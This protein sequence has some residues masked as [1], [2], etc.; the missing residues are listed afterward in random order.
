MNIQFIRQCAKCGSRVYTLDE[1]AISCRV[2][3]DCICVT[4]YQERKTQPKDWWKKL[5]GIK[6]F[7]DFHKSPHLL[8]NDTLIETLKNEYLNGNKHV[9]DLQKLINFQNE[10]TLKGSEKFFTTMQEKKEMPLYDIVTRMDFFIEGVNRALIQITPTVKLFIGKT[11]IKK[12]TFNEIRN[13]PTSITNLLGITQTESCLECSLTDFQL[14]QFGYPFDE[15]YYMFE[16]YQGNYTV[17]VYGVRVPRHL[18]TYIN[19][20]I[21]YKCNVTPELLMIVAGGY[22]HFNR[23]R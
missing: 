17:I 12:Q 4:C 7:L 21:D 22:S 13:E 19:G 6:H 2:H 1:L 8:T 3:C 14:P 5:F 10:K 20:G 11:L 16:N 9:L 15:R 18:K 23:V